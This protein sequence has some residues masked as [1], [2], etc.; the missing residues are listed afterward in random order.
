MVHEHRF[1]F[2]SINLLKL[3]NILK[4]GG[5]TAIKSLFSRETVPTKV[6]NFFGIHHI[7]VKDATMH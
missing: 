7:L 3:H 1:N 4:I 2:L 6:S 5:I